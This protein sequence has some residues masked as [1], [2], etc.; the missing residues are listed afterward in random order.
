MILFLHQLK[1]EKPNDLPSGDSYTQTDFTVDGTQPSI[2]NPMGN[3]IL[4][5]CYSPEQVGLK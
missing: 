5:E 4:G 1:G 2:S 3:P